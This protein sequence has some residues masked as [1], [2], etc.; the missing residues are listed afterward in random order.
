MNNKLKRVLPKT[1]EN[2]TPKRMAVIPEYM[3]PL[4]VL[5]TT[6]DAQGH[7]QTR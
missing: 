2:H 1:N 4:Q 7:I 3:L 5:V 6:V